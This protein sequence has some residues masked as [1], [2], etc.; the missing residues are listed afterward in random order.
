MIASRENILK[1]L[2]IIFISVLCLVIYTKYQTS[3]V[4]LDQ[5][6]KIGFSFLLFVNILIFMTLLIGAGCVIRG[7]TSITLGLVFVIIQLFFLEDIASGKPSS[8]MEIVGTGV[9]IILF[10]EC[11][12]RLRNLE[13]FTE[14][15]GIVPEDQRRLSDYVTTLGYYVPNLREKLYQG[16][17]V[18]VVSTD[19]FVVAMIGIAVGVGLSFTFL[20]APG[21]AQLSLLQLMMFALLP[22][23]IFCLCIHRI[24]TE[25]NYYVL[26]RSGGKTWKGY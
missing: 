6:M 12:Q 17:Y 24:Y 7:M 15:A 21:N 10:I 18:S 20:E 5:K 1:S 11:M 2:G 4:D 22:L 13:R 16:N 26:R 23:S 25:K 19:Y 3:D 14:K 9:L 8:A